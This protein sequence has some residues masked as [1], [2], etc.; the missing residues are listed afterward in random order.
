MT[1]QYLRKVRV[2]LATRVSEEEGV[3]KDFFR[4]YTRQTVIENLKV[5]FS[6]TK[7]LRKEPNPASITIHNLAEQTRAEFLSY[8]AHI[9]L[10]A[11]YEGDMGVIYKGDV[12]PQG[13]SNRH[14][15][16][17]WLTT[18][19]CGTGARAFRHGRVSQSFRAGTDLKTL[20][21]SAAKSMGLKLPEKG[22]DAKEFI[23]QIAQGVTLEGPS[24]SQMETLLNAK[25]FSHSV[26]D[27]QL[28][29]YRIGEARTEEAIVISP[30]TG[31]VGSPEF[32]AP[33]GKKKKTVL[34]VKTLLDRS[35]EPRKLIQVRSRSINGNFRILSVAHTGD[36]HGQAWYSEIEA[37]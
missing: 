26:Q 23:S 16:T 21:S 12:R 18:V 34:R 11:G 6:I 2:T 22:T 13:A 20:V 32:E 10:S 36:T 28:Q 33:S 8:P 37:S 14:E 25:G 24:Q 7:N 19:E 3:K 29:I 1:V 31:M 4:A 30:D 27:D 17:E 15:G 35:L 5:T 9:T